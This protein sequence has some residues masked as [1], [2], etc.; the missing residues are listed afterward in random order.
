SVSV[1]IQH[2]RG[3]ELPKDVTAL[4]VPFKQPESRWI[5]LS[6]LEITFCG[7]LGKRRKCQPEG[8]PCRL[9]NGETRHLKNYV[10]A[11][12]EAHVVL[13][14]FIGLILRDGMKE[15]QVTMSMVNLSITTL[16]LNASYTSEKE[17][18]LLGSVKDQAIA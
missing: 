11:M 13:S 17:D 5:R 15:N 8:V 7:N 18:L 3:I 16:T 4:S 2:I 14:P 10:W 1:D 12:T 6:T 9:R